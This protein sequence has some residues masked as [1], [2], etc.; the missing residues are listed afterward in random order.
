MSRLFGLL[1]EEAVNLSCKQVSKL[2]T[3]INVE[4]AAADMPPEADGWGIGFYRNRGA[5]LFKKASRN[6]RVQ[7]ITN[8]TEVVSSSIFISHLRKATVGDRKEAN[9]HPFRWG[10]W[11]FAHLGTISRF[12]KIRPRIL[13]TLPPAY[14]KQIHGNTDSE[15][16]FYLYLSMLR[17]EGGIKKGQIPLAAAVEGLKN[18]GRILEEFRRDAEIQEISVLNF[19]I[20]N[21]TYLLALR[22]EHPLYY[23]SYEEGTTEE[24]RFFSPTTWL[25]YEIVQYDPS[26]KIVVVASEKLTASPNWREVPEKHILAIESKQEINITPWLSDKV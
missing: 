17:G 12:R 14:K 21:G 25:E 9:T 18:F 19:L 11:L 20:S 15:H 26:N 6:S 23:V 5:F 22:C 16:L 4:E 1:C 8:I 7:R 3:G 13:R 10:N 24:T 2:P